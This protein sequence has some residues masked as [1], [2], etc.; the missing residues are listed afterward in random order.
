MKVGIL[1]PL[2][3]QIILTKKK[4][5]IYAGSHHLIPWDISTNMQN[6]IIELYNV[7][8]KMLKFKQASIRSSMLTRGLSL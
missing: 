7:D 4:E 1:I 8:S 6:E 3:I 5:N 2:Q